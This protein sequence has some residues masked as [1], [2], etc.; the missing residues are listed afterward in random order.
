MTT[1]KIL[2]IGGI[3]L[4]VGLYFASCKPSKKV[5]EKKDTT[6]EEIAEEPTE[7]PMAGSDCK[8]R[9]INGIATITYINNANPDQVIIKY[10]FTPI[11]KVPYKYPKFSDKGIKFFVK[12]HGS[13]PPQSWVKENGIKM[14]AEIKCVRQEIDKGSCTPVVFAFPQ[15]EKNGWSE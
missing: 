3:L 1:T 12:G 15:F 5:V 4:L 2:I 7:E 9:G 13:F 11:D 8:Y 14:G 6:V 10:D